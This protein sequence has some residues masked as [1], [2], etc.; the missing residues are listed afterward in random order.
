MAEATALRNNAL[1]Y[2]VYGA[3]WTIIVPVLDADG[4]LVTGAASL[5]SEIS[6]N[7]DTFADC[8]N[9]ATEIATSSGM[10]Y[11]S[12]TGTELTTDVASIIIKTGTAGAKTTPV[13]LYPRKL[14]TIRSGTAA[15]AGSLT[16]TIIL[17][18]GASAVDDYY[19]GMVVIATI[20]GN[21]EARVISDYTGSSKS[22]AVSPDWNVAPDSDDTF[23]IKLPEGGQVQQADALA[24]NGTAVGTPHTAGYPVVT[25]KD[26]TGTGEIDT[27]AGAIVSVT[28]TATA[29][30]VTTVNGLAAGVITE[31]SIANNAITDAKVASDV[32]I[33]SVTGAVGSVTGAVGSVTGSVGS[34]AAGGIT[35]SS[36]ATDAIGS[37][38]LAASA[39]TKIWA[40]VADSAGVTTLLTRITA[41]LQTKAEADTAHGLLATAASLATVATNVSTAVTQT[42]AA[43]IRTALGLASA[44]LDTQLDAVPTA[45]ENADAVWTVGNMTAAA[46]NRI[47]D[48]VLR[49][50]TAN[51][52]ASS[53][54]DT[55]AGR[56][57][58][59]AVARLAHKVAAVTGTMTVYKSD[60]STSLTTATLTTDATA[61]PVVTVDPAA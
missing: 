13:V 3:P 42:T 27:N 39:V 18:S 24:W 41:V 9:E 54:G 48:V 61:D 44:N 51:V 34:V 20:D 4:D 38:E 57:L 23:I 40:A 49:R 1:P 32:T 15:S 22:A 35:A 10:Y 33:A 46:V 60:D 28:T 8:T 47:A 12:L 14:V 56:S 19:N 25:V 55:V 36:I 53:Y 16:S 21:V 29:T 6:K 50:T 17:D 45:T 30:N 7:G 37:D 52:E 2:P 11:L 58:Y 59:G 31:T 5:D 43:A 26:G